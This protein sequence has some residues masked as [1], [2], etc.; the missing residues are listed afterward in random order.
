MH[1]I[2]IYDPSATDFST[3]GRG[4]L[5]PVECTIEEQANGKYE[6][7]LVQP[8][9]D[10]MRW[11]LIDNGCIV[12]AA[13]PVRE[14][15]M[16]E[17][18]AFDGTEE[19]AVTVTRSIYKV[20]TNGSR[21]MLRQ[22]PTTESPILGRYYTGTEVVQLADAGDGWYQV[23]VVSGG[24]TGYM[25]ARWLQYDRT[26][27][28]TLTESRPVKR[29]G[30]KVQP[31][32]DQLFR[33]HSVERDTQRGV[34]TVAAM[35]ITYDLRGNIVG[36][37]Y[38]PENVSAA[39]AGA[40]A[41]AAMLNAH[42]FELVVSTDAPVSGDFGWKSGIELLLEPETG[43]AA[44]TGGNLI[45]DNYSLYLL[46]DVERDMGVT[47]RRGKN[48]IGVTVDSDASGVVTRIIPVG[49]NADGD[50]L[51]IDGLY[52]DSPY[53]GMYPTVMTQRI[54]YDVRVGESEED[55]YYPDDASAK[56]ELARLAA[57]DF[58]NGVDL[59]A[60]GMEVDFVP[61]DRYN[62]DVEDYAGL[63]AV[64]LFDTVRVIDE[65]YHIDAKIRVTAYTWDVLAERYTGV[66]LG[67]LV[68]TR[69]VTYG[70]N[71]AQGSVSGNRL[72][73]NTVDGTMLRDLSV[74]MGKFDIATVRQL[75]AEAINALTARI[76]EIA[77]GSI[78]TDELYA[79]LSEIV[80]LM[81]ENI[82]ADTIAT[83]Q[84]AAALGEFV[85]LYADF[86]G[87]DF[88]AV[89]D[90]LADEAIFRAGTAGELYIDRLAA[91]SATLVSAVV[92]ELT[93]K[94]ADGKYYSVTV[95]SDGT[96]GTAEVVPTEGEIEAGTTEDGRAIVETSANIAELSAQTIKG[97]SAILSEIFTDALT[98]GKITAGQA[99]IAS[100]TIPE[101]YTTAIKAI[102][103]SIDISA[104][105][106]IQLLIATNDLIRA[107][108]TFTED[109]MRVGKQGSTYAT[110]TDDTG[111]HI[112][113][114]NEIIGSFAKR[115]L[116]AESI[117]VGPVNGLTAG[118]RVVMRGTSSGGVAFVAE[119]AT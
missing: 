5:L 59:P 37:T 101:L 51:Y 42:P 67:E 103:D 115:Q 17:I 70:F 106:T 102:G 72:I 113:Q 12:K 73:P 78:T 27:T 69:S 82:T 43:L 62:T 50:D 34:V 30:V 40:H 87:L 89:K 44:Q 97:A 91:T 94:G 60:Y 35:H 68:S 26:I 45:R 88:A 77:A 86:A 15:P 2:P 58:A 20:K 90:L 84:L 107:W 9:T 4:L 114:L 98:A 14:S 110:L 64:H 66:T 79:S 109:G 54:E 100:A 85:A 108:Y 22:R 1:G 32:R 81:A 61:L 117:R 16:Y 92:G 75:N 74:K 119:D 3:N 38:S 105:T 11:T 99:M 47:I 41:F 46:P 63:Q 28:E 111:F 71:I 104:N 6:L 33:I 48:L 118:R 93:L 83:D 80:T 8:M 29:E 24:A 53:L 21:L 116:A 49:K 56:T 55:G 95:Q 25:Y 31:A 57:Q 65:L 18:S 96:V 13:A 36:E 10:D 112:L 7:K 39:E 23:S 52:V 76:S 19:T